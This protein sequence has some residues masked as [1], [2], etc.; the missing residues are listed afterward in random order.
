[1]RGL[2]FV[3]FA[4]IA[5]L[6]CGCV[7]L[8]PPGPHQKVI[9]VAISDPFQS[10]TPGAAPVVL[11]AV[12][13]EDPADRGVVWS[14]TIDGANCSPGCGTLV[15]SPPPSLTA[16]YTPPAM[17]SGADIMPTITAVS[18]TDPTKKASFTFTI[19]TSTPISVGLSGTFQSIFAAGPPQAILA[20][21]T[22]DNAGVQWTMTSAGTACSLTCGTLASGP[23]PSLGALYTPPPNLAASQNPVVT[24]TATSVT[25]TSKNNSFSFTI[26]EPSKFTYVFLLRGYD[27]AGIP[28]AMAGAFVVDSNGNITGGELDLNDGGKI[29]HIQ[30]VLGNYVTEASF[31]G[32][33][34]ASV[35]IANAVLPGTNVN[36]AFK[37]VLRGS[38]TDGEIIEFDGGGYLTAGTVRAQSGA[39][40]TVPAGAYIFGIDSDFPVGQR[41][42]ENGA[43]EIQT[44]NT[45]L[46]VTDISQ[47]EGSTRI[48]NAPVTGSATPSDEFGRGTISLECNGTTT[49]YAYYVVNDARL[50][51]FGSQ[52]YLMQISGG[53]DFG[54]VL[55]GIAEGDTPSFDPPH[56]PYHTMILQIT[57]MDFPAGSAIPSPDVAIGALTISPNNSATFTFDANDAGN[58]STGVII[59]GTLS[60]YDT[61][62]GRGVI[63]FPNGFTRGF[64]DT[65]VF[66]LF[67][68]GNGF[69]VDGD[70]AG[71]GATRNKAF[72][73]TLSRQLAGPFDA[74]SL[75]GGLIAVSGASA[76]PTIPN[77]EIA[78]NADPASE[79]ASG[80]AYATSTEEG[81]FS[82]ITVQMTYSVPDP[83]SGH[84][85]GMVSAGFFGDFTPHTML[86][87][88]YYFIGGNQL[89]WIGTQQGIPSGVTFVGPE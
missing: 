83:V 8:Q 61:N 44:G 29:A 32:V 23:A 5:V 88:S 41:V 40:G 73:G 6:V 16:I 25:D 64:V 47:A 84:G 51:V 50:N 24:I 11:T 42:V 31:A 9:K 82:D 53:F 43:F 67:D 80:I 63:S 60:A 55:A 13:E 76:S 19:Q 72:S 52:L 71:N 35:T 18:V 78:L 22:N 2:S 77:S 26:L 3:I 7:A 36:P 49:Q 70:V 14:L 28:L 89:V 54:T 1:M 68:N 27:A 34:R 17:L 62:T 20:T 37:Y 10:A 15:P 45:V 66:Y 48:V 56:A 87:V 12:V 79:S 81:Q 65:A 38:Q 46:G 57:G 69:M 74:S 58:V 30:P 86:P 39:L 59:A 4:L 85:I 75:S 21:V 33:T